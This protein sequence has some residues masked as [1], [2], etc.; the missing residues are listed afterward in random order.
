MTD[1]Y[2]A[3]V[4]GAGPAGSSAAYIMAQAGLEVALLERGEYP[5]CKNVYGGTIYREPTEEIIPAFWHEAPL[6]RP[7]VSDELWLA[8]QDSAVKVGFSGL[9]F[10]KE[11]YNKFTA[12]RAK[13]DR[14]LANKAAEAGAEVRT[15]ALVRHLLYEKSLVG[16]NK[17]V[18]GVQLDSG[19]ELRSNV[20]ILAEGVNAFLTKEAGLRSKTPAHTM[21]LYVR[22]IL[23]LPAEKIEERFNLEKGEGAIIGIIGYPTAGAVGK[24]GL[25]TNKDS[26]SLIAGAYLDQMVEKGLSPYEMLWRTKT[27]PLV[28]RL[29]EGAESIEYQSH[30]IPKGGYAFIPKLYFSG[31]LVIGDA[32]M[33]IS[34]RR[35]TDLAMLT[36]K[37]AAETV[38]LAKAKGDFTGKMLATYA[39]KL[40]STFFMKDIK[41]GKNSLDYYKK[42]QDSD[43]LLAS[44]ANELAYQFFTVDMLSDKERQEKMI[45]TVLAKQLPFKTAVDLYEAYKNWEVF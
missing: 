40:N 45:G 32:A 17:K 4:V 8:G 28:K 19:E 39:H 26:I 43:Y 25:Y 1:S 9:R 31:L 37:Y 14:W 23:H 29:L 21:T 5:G 13:F 6:E 35:G 38:I 16:K 22:E 3:I 30:M 42:H 2:D 36:G 33:M 10:A 20:V 41:T 44:T 12:L 18:L 34:G 24:A 27:H 7:V 15:K 11:P